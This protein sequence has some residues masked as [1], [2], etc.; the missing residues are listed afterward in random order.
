MVS[1]L[2]KFISNPLFSYG[3]QRKRRT[4]DP[5]RR[6]STIHLILS[7]KSFKNQVFSE[8]FHRDYQPRLHRLF[9]LRLRP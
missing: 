3:P 4:L 1:R 2:H 7:F 9:F 5:S 6:A 8:N